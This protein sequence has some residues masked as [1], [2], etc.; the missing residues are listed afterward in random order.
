MNS[1]YVDMAYWYESK[2]HGSKPL[3]NGGRHGRLLDFDK[4]CPEPC[5]NE[6][7]L[8]DGV[9]VVAA[10]DNGLRRVELDHG[11]S[12][13][14]GETRL[15]CESGGR[16]ADALVGRGPGHTGGH[17]MILAK[18]LELKEAMGGIVE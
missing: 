17:G 10:L 16:V 4:K 12:K 2:K 1:L 7:L 13:P 3:L 11:L 15:F 8:G 14:V 6:I 9:L 18:G 5:F